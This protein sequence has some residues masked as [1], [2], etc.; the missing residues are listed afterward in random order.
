M[1][2]SGDVLVV[3]DAESMGRGEDKQL[4]RAVEELIKEVD[5]EKQK[6]AVQAEKEQAAE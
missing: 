2:G 3:N 1:L 5:A 6:K 4:A